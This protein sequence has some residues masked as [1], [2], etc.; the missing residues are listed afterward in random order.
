M[1]ITYPNSEKVYLNGQLYPDLRVAMRQVNLTPTVTK[2]ADG[3]KHYKENA[4]VMVYDT[5]GPYSDPQAEIDLKEGLPRL[6]EAWIKERGGVEQ[7]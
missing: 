2:D 5:S 4:P 7:L 6:R 1:K 3:T